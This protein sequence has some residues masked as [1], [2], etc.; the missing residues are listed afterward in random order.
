M[1]F[2]VL[3][4][5]VWSKNSGG[6]GG[7]TGAAPPQNPPLNSIGFEVQKGSMLSGLIMKEKNITVQTSTNIIFSYGLNIK[8][9]FANLLPFLNDID[10]L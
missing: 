4:A 2:P 7:G 6:W 9:C 1:L 3:T 10:N 5:S 8:P